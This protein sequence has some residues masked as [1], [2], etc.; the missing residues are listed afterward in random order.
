M[1]VEISDETG[2]FRRRNV[3]RRA[4]AAL[5]DEYGA[6][7]RELTVVLV[8]DETMA[9][10]NAAHR[11]VSGPTD[12]LSYPLHEPDDVGVPVVSALGDIVVSLD[13]AT[14]Q[15]RERRVA[16]YREV[17]V[18]CAHGLLHLLGFDHRD[19]ASW[20]PFE[21]AQ[22]RVLALAAE[23]G[24]SSAADPRPPAAAA[25]AESAEGSP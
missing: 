25:P 15:A 17:L 19:A 7:D 2:R 24:R 3:L 6:H 5:G 18:L 11:G 1:M 21:A 20:R 16:T 13:T 10:R 8:D 14:R 12:V 9:A 23:E 22:R 4:L